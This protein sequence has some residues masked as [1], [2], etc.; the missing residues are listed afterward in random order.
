VS[1]RPIAFFAIDR[2][3]A[4]TAA[5]IV[6]RVGRRWRLLGATACPSGTD[7]NA[8]LG[9]LVAR[10]QAAD[11]ELAASLGVPR[12]LAGNARASALLNRDGLVDLALAPANLASVDWPSLE[13]RSRPAPTLAIVS[14]TERRRE[15]LERAAVGS[16][17]R[18]VSASLERS[19]A[20][21][22]MSVALGND[23]SAVLLGA[24][25]Q[26]SSDERQAL[27]ILGP[28]IVAVAERR[29]ELPI[30]LVGAVATGK[31]AVEATRMDPRSVL[32]VRD[33]SETDRGTEALRRVLG[34]LNHDP[35]DSRRGIARA[36]ETLASIL[37]RRVEA[38]EIGMNGGA[39]AA[40]GRWLGHGAASP[41]RTAVIADAGLARA[42]PDD[43]L[44]DGVIGW[45]SVA[46]DRSR[47]RDRLR[48]LWL[49]PWAEAHGEGALLRLTA[50]R[51]AL[52][53][54]VAATPEFR[55]MP[56]PDLLVIAGGVW[57]V[58]P[59]P[60]VVVAVLDVIRRSGVSQLVLDH[61]RLLGPIGAIADEAER[62]DLLA[63]LMDDALTPLGTAV[64][65]QGLRAGRYVGRAVVHRPNVAPEEHELVAGRLVTLEVPPGETVSA[66]LAF[67]DTIVV[68]G[69]GRRFALDVAGGMGGV[70]VDLRDVPLRLPDRL[71]R[72]RDLL[73]AWQ[74]PLW[75]PLES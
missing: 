4:T 27:R 61:A 22:V 20:L 39:R 43:E 48:E 3:S 69:R 13:A 65:P 60:A 36:T 8:M 68:G 54:L 46:I 72:R 40:A 28:I 26:A 16:G 70:L 41:A 17:W 38:V 15:M 29:P 64:V 37:D 58:A 35:A 62:A 75:S 49:A 6:G 51:A 71:E 1:D 7:T 33:G 12:V 42:E 50:A 14:P 19:D 47:L 73:A 21:E 34:D 2:G 74:Q 53:R 66:E 11:P 55:T 63:D 59:T 24:G 25:S 32:V 5:S 44:L 23:V 45:S 52:S 9:L 18:L 56:S 57:S 31:A 67:R 10:L 30:V